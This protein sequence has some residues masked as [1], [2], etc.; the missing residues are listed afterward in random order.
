MVLGVCVFLCEL[1]SSMGEE[2]RAG[3][4]GELIR[5]AL[6]DTRFPRGSQRAPSCGVH[7]MLHWW[8][9]STA[10]PASAEAWQERQFSSR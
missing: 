9:M 5:R 10:T 3:H 8:L 7:E 1:C 2:I 4:H 6:A